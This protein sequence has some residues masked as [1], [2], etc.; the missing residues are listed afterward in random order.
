MSP[1]NKKNR[2][3]LYFQLKSLI[4][5]R[6]DSGE[7]KPGTQ[8]PSERELCDQFKISRITVRQAIAELVNEGRLTRWHG[9]GTYVAKPHVEQKLSHL[10]GFTQ[11]M[12][13]RGQQP[14]AHVVEIEVRP[15]PNHVARALQIKAGEPVIVLRRLRLADGEP[16]SVETSHL[17]DRLCHELVSENLENRSLY[18]TL[19]DKFDLHP[20]RAE[21]QMRAAACAPAEAKLLGIRRGSPVLHIHRTTYTHDNLPFEFVESVYRGDKYVFHAEL[22]HN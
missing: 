17:L 1:L 19:S 9:R 8:V 2:Q 21:Q 14:G 4:D 15:A 10:T 11:D 20:A 6:I 18:K 3:P 16:M 5:Q 12:Q 7:W 22:N 13:A